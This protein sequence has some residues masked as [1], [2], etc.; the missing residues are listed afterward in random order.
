MDSPLAAARAQRLEGYDVSPAI[1]VLDDLDK[2]DTGNRQPSAAVRVQDL[3]AV[4][5]RS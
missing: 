2:P 5:H 1:L 3:G 4:S